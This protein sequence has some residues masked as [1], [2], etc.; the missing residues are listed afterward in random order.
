[1]EEKG[2]MGFIKIYRSIVEW[3]WY[4]DIPVRVLFEHCLLKANHTEKRWRGE[5]IPRGS[6]I[7]SLENLS[8]ETGLTVS[9]VRTA[10]KK[11]N[12]TNEIASKGHSSYSV[13]T[14]NNYDLFQLND[15]QNDKQIANKSQTN[16]NN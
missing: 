9:Q 11:L 15:K 1:M 3:E 12:L 8:Y 2:K 7:T 13:I 16:R 14:V 10:L 5:I 4:T 6:F